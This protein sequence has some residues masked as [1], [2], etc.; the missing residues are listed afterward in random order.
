MAAPCTG[1]TQ[2]TWFPHW[3]YQRFLIFSRVRLLH[4]RLTPARALVPPPRLRAKRVG[5]SAYLQLSQ[6]SAVTGLHCRR[7]EG[8]NSAKPCEQC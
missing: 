4:C 5:Y 8:R 2:P 7:W 1:K 6:K 3:P